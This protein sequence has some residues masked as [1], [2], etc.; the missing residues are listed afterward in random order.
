MMKRTLLV[1]TMMAAALA[2][3]CAWRTYVKPPGDPDWGVRITW[4]GHSCFLFEDSMGRRFLIDP[5]DETVGYKLPFVKTDA[6]LITHDHFDHNAFSRAAGRYDL[7][8]ST[9]VHIAAGVEVTGVAGSHDD[10]EGR[11]HGD[12]IFYA[13]TMGGVRLAHLSDVGPASLS[14]EQRRELGPVDVLFVPVG[15]RTT[16]DAEGAFNLTRQINPRVVVPMHYGNP[17]VRFFEF[18]PVDPFVERFPRKVNVP[19]ASFL[20]RRDNLPGETTV[21]VPRLPEP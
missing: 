3:G 17:Q 20:I 2:A 12:V 8:V 15:G 18:D 16:V 13:W 5:F 11:R 7:V 4:F 19:D 9:G 1:L 10:V 21:Y 6:L 14:E